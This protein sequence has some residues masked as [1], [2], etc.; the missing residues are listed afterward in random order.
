MLDQLLGG[1][2]TQRFGR[3]IQQFEGGSAHK[4]SGQDAAAHHD[5]IAKHLTPQQYE[6][7]AIAAASKLTPEQRKE[8]AAKLTEAAKAQ[9]HPTAAAAAKH[10]ADPTSADSIG[11]LLSAFQ[12]SPGGVTGLLSAG[13]AMSL[14]GNP[15]VRSALTGVAAMAA[16]Q[17]I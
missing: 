2:A 3:L 17:F 8:L 5:E 9:G 11:K 6:Q 16:K 15:T 4:V 7:A 1:D 12:G 14:L 10:G 13:G